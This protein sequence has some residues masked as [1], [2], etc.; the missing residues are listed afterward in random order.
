MR[1]APVRGAPVR[2]TPTRYSNYKKGIGMTTFLTRMATDAATVRTAARLSVLAAA[3]MAAPTF[4][5]EQIKLVERPVGETTIDLAAKGDSVGDMLVF[6]NTVFDAA[7]KVQVGTDQGYCVRT[8]VGK[9]WE[10]IWTLTLK[11]G[12]ITIEGPFSDAGDSIFAVT[13]GTG[14]YAGAKG[15][16]K[17]HPRD[18]TPTGYDFTYD[19]L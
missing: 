4:A 14:K 17:L 10:C 15:S 2:S 18:A 16:M 3:L 11:A 13:G 12:Q 7:N 6:A 8:V 9:S 5:A 19:L 1:R